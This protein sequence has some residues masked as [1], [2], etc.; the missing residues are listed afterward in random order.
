MSTLLLKVNILLSVLFTI[1]E[2]IFI[3]FPAGLDYISVSSFRL[4]FSGAIT[5]ISFGID[6]IQDGLTELS[7]FFYASIS[8]VTLASGGN[9]IAVTSG[10]RIRII[11]RIQHAQVIISDDDSKLEGLSHIFNLGWYYNLP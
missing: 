4:L 1:G 2:E 9:Y 6:I 8:D 5:S 10:I 11:F 7:E 3:L